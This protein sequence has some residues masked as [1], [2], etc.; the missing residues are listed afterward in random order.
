MSSVPTL[1]ETFRRRGRCGFPTARKSFHTVP[2]PG[3][4]LTSASIYRLRIIVA[5]N[6]ASASTGSRSSA[7][8]STDNSSV[9]KDNGVRYD[10]SKRHLL[11]GVDSEPS[12][13][14]L[15]NHQ[16]RACL[17]QFPPI[18][19]RGQSHDVPPK[20]KQHILWENSGTPVKQFQD[21]SN[22]FRRPSRITQ[23]TP[24]FTAKKSYSNCPKSSSRMKTQIAP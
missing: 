22:R 15:S 19:G 8:A 21:G 17:S 5:P 6:R 4:R 10:A 11:S 16:L 24:Q 3:G 2:P 12:E 13:S 20:I 1:H 9:A 18:M 14:C 7:L 23:G